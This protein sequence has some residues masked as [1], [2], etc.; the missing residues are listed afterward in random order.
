[1]TQPL[2]KTYFRELIELYEKLLS[3]RNREESELTQA[4]S[5][6]IK[7]HSQKHSGLASKAESELA[8]LRLRMPFFESKP[9]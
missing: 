4:I 7:I 2:N 1:M 3:L 6:G 5:Y 9:S 8:L